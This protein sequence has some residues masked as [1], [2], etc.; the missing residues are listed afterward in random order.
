MFA[1]TDCE[2]SWICLIHRVLIILGRAN[3]SSGIQIFL[4]E[5][6][7]RRVQMMVVTMAHCVPC[8]VNWVCVCEMQRMQ[9]KH[10]SGIPH[11]KLVISFGGQQSAHEA[12]FGA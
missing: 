9:P 3:F 5:V 10:R 2:Q 6:H 7:S 8:Q 12:T 4:L 1:L 11:P